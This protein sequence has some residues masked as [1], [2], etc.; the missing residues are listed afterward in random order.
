[1]GRFRD[2]D[3]EMPYASNYVTSSKGPIITGGF[4]Q[5]H[6]KRIALANIK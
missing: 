1:M 5:N 2:D 6:H 4:N 3:F